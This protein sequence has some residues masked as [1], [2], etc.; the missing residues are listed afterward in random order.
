ML[1][2]GEDG[3]KA[4]EASDVYSCGII[5]WELS[6]RGEV[7]PKLHPH[8]LDARPKI[9]DECPKS[10]KS[11]IEKSWC[12]EPSDRIDA[13]KMLNLLAHGFSEARAAGAK[14]WYFDG[15]MDCIEAKDHLIDAPERDF[16]FVHQLYMK[17]PVPGMDI[18]RVQVIDNRNNVQAFESGVH[19]LQNKDASI[20]APHYSEENNADWRQ[21]VIDMSN[22]LTATYNDEDYE[23]IHFAPL[24]HATGQDAVNG[25]IKS[26]LVHLRL[27]DGATDGG[28]F[29]KGYYFTPDA[30]YAYEVYGRLKHAPALLLFWTAYRSAYPVI[31]GDMSKLHG[32]PKYENYDAHYVP[33]KPN[34]DDPKEKKFYPCSSNED[35]QYTEVVL[36]DTSQSLPKY[37]I[38]LKPSVTIHN[39][40]HPLEGLDWWRVCDDVYNNFLSKEFTNKITETGRDVSNFDWSYTHDGVTV[41]RPNHGLVHTIRT[42]AY[43][44]FVVDCVISD[45]PDYD[46]D[47][48]EAAALRAAIPWIQLTLLFFVAGRKNDA[49]MDWD[50][51]A[52]IDGKNEAADAMDDYM[53]SCGFQKERV[54]YWSNMIRSESKDIQFGILLFCHRVDLVRCLKED[55]YD[56]NVNEFDSLLSPSVICFSPFCINRI[57]LICCS[58]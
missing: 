12:A 24:W 39:V 40:L 27:G 11:I 15:E 34:S 14:A 43:V 57:S 5:L 26:G 28:Y 7:P 19:K 25:I 16:E 6:N 36:F 17:N 47:D 4:T 1:K 52:Y 38:T 18:A 31:D 30:K 13:L 51:Q 53:Q 46:D 22:E 23:H 44:P 45:W 56:S 37:V 54:Q 9:S 33:V 41:H 32:K 55:V 20:C 10:L 2:V 49:P 8:A 21:S 3:I 58:I 42:M 50:R 35:H 29:G 48:D